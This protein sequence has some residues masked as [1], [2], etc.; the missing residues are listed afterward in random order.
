MKKIL[1]IDD[2]QGI[3]ETTAEI[4]ELENFNVLLAKNGKEGIE[5]VLKLK[6]DLIIC[7]IKMPI[8]DGYEVIKYLKKESKTAMIP[9]IILTAKTEKYDIKKVLE[10]G[11]N[12]HVSKPFDF[13]SLLKLINSL[14]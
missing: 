14:I 3:R 5:N 13:E 4:L 2:N 11:A 7:D 10:L 9:I 12:A 6:P 8:M 1:I